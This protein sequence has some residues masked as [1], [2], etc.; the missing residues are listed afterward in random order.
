MTGF[1]AQFPPPLLWACALLLGLLLVAFFLRQPSVLLLA[2]T[3]NGRLVIS[4]RALHRLIEHCCE[5]INGV[6]A[7]HASV[8]RRRKQLRTEIRLKIR[9]NAKL[10]AIQGYLTQ[11]IGDIFRENLGLKEFGRI[12]VKVIGVVSENPGF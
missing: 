7:A 8:T 3:E 2:S 5:Q 1:L 11:E 12:D 9:P 10:D 4:R 6:A